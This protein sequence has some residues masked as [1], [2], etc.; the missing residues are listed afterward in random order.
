MTFVREDFDM[1]ANLFVGKSMNFMLSA[2]LTK[3]AISV[4]AKKLST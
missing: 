1:K 3:T 4:F 2:S